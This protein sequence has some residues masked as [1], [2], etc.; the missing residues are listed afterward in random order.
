MKT[1]WNDES[2][3]IVSAEIVLV[4]TILVLGMITGL[5][6]L[7]AAVIYELTDLSDAF[8]NLDQTFQTSG[9]TSRKNN[10]CDNKARTK[11]SRYNDIVD[12]CDCSGLVIVCNDLG[13]K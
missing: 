13:E 4:G 12:D 1:L 7:Q 9:F 6:E 2:G 5:V 11:G 3:V 8:G 10:T